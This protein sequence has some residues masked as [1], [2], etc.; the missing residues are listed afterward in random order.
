MGVVGGFSKPKGQKKV[1]EALRP[2]YPN[3]IL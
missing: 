1:S 3:Y 2:R